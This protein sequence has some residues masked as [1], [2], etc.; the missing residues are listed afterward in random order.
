M[1]PVLTA[2]IG[3]A[4]LASVGWSKHS[5]ALEA[6]QPLEDS[7]VTRPKLSIPQNDGGKSQGSLACVFRDHR[8]KILHVLLC[9]FE[10]SKACVLTAPVPLRDL[11]QKF[12]ATKIIKIGSTPDGCSELTFR[13]SL[14][15][16]E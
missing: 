4:L 16:P 10:K 6:E 3:A 14:K 1:K 9:R 8:S 7:A 13:G 2:L 5:Y 12:E 15:S 11:L